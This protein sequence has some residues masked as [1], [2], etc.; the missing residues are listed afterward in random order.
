MNNISNNSLRTKTVILRT[1]T[2][3]AHLVVMVSPE[4]LAHEASRVS[5]VSRDWLDHRDRVAMLDQVDHQDHR[6]QPVHKVLVVSRDHKVCGVNLDCEEN[7]DRQD[8]QV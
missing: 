2:L 6:D 7:R 3:Q 5:A 4:L 8:N 1:R